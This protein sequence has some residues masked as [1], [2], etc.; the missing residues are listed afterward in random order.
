MR[1]QGNLKSLSM[2]VVVVGTTLAMVV[3]A[4]NARADT[5]VIDSFATPS[6]GGDFYSFT[7]NPSASPPISPLTPGDMPIVIPGVG[8]DLLVEVVGDIDWKS[9]IGT[10]GSVDEVLSVVTFGDSGTRVTLDY[11]SWAGKANTSDLTDG[12]T[13]NALAFAFNFLGAGDLN[14]QITV[15]GDGGEATFKS[16]GSA[17]G[18]V[19]QS[20]TPFIYLAPFDEFDVDTGNPLSNA[21]TISIL[22]NDPVGGPIANVSFELTSVAAVPEP[23]TLAMLLTLGATSLLAVARRRRKR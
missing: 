15:S 7:F 3:Y 5:I 10:I 6:V 8:R 20:S 4:P 18:D 16:D 19:A 17:L 22:F 2:F 13:N 9:V 1:V 23:S 21:D 12:G 14:V 11:T